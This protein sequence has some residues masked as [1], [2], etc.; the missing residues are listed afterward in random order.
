MGCKDSV[1]GRA[2]APA[3]HHTRSTGALVLHALLL[4]GRCG[5]QQLDP[6]S[7]STA[8]ELQ[9][10]VSEAPFNSTLHVTIQEH[11]DLRELEIISTSAN[12]NELM[13]PVT[14]SLSIRVRLPPPSHP[15]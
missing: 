3:L 12:S 11:L 10:L 6:V 7:V 13:D 1:D 15:P 5:A 8:Q 14:S 2:R 9:T 4:V